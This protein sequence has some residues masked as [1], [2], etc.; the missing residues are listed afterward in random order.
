MNEDQL[1]KTGS[2][3]LIL[4]SYQ[5]KIFEYLRGDME[6]LNPEFALNGSQNECTRIDI[7]FFPSSE[8]NKGA[9]SLRYHE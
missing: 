3:T 9:V 1:D 8:I 5:S 6:S 4:V 2:I 7:V